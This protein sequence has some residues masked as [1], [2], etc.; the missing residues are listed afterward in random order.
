MV[1]T[2]GNNCWYY[3]DD[4]HIVGDT[5]SC[6]GGGGVFVVKAHKTCPAFIWFGE[7]WGLLGL[8]VTGSGW[9]A[10]VESRGLVDVVGREVVD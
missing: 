7:V 3:P 5:P 8:A 6:V 9:D 10:G 1:A 4:G 2:K